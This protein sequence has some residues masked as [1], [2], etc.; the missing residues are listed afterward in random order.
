VRCSKRGAARVSPWA[1]FIA[2]LLGS[3]RLRVRD[4]CSARKVRATI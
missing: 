4:G 1:A 3:P 2:P